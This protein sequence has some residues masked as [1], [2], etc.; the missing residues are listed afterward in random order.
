MI[1]IDP[2]N[3]IIENINLLTQGKISYNESSTIDITFKNKKTDAKRLLDILPP[4]IK[5]SFDAIQLSGDLAIDGFV[6]GNVNNKISLGFDYLLYN[7]DLLIKESKIGIN[8]LHA[9]GQFLM[10]NIGSIENAQFNCGFKSASKGNNQIK[11]VVKVTNFKKPKI[12]WKGKAQIDPI[13]IAQFSD[14]SNFIPSGGNINLDGTLNLVYDI[15]QSKIEPKSFH[16]K[17]TVNLNNIQGQ[18]TNPKISVHQ[19]NIELKTDSNRLVFNNGQINYNQTQAYLEGYISTIESIFDHQSKSKLIG[20]LK[21]DNLNINE[22]LVENTSPKTVNKSDELSPFKF[23]LTTEIKN[24]KVNDF[25]AQSLKG[26]FISDKKSI[27]MSDLS[28]VALDGSVHGKIIM[29]NWGDHYLLDIQSKLEEVNIQKMFKQFDNFYQNEITDKNIS[30]TLNGNLIAKII[31]NDDYEPIL[32]KLYAKSTIEVNNGS[33]TG[34]EPLKELS[35]FVD[36]KDLENVKFKKL[37]NSIEIF[38][39]TIF[40]PKMKIE[41]NALNLEIE[42]THTFD[43]LMSYAMEISIAELLATKANWIAKKA[44]KRIER[45]KTGGLTAYVMIEGTPDDL[46]IRY[47]RSTVKENIKEEVKNEKKKFIQTLKGENT[48]ED[49]KVNVKNYEDVWDE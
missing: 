30:G 36:I 27:Q 20:H 37:E 43:N 31:L 28:M 3:L 21:I 16:Y 2:S 35:S 39:E 7:A 12:K 24:F 23:N 14:N 13:F 33:L 18:I 5:Q 40:I 42:G 47:D 25:V 6:K 46:K 44:E 15:N 38:D 41:N 45:N 48:L 1:T 9:S 26:R 34:Y 17:G 32:P 8:Q 4:N 49:Q 19:L 29:K 22:L 11:G 10:P